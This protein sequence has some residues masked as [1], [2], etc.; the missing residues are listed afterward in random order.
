MKKKQYSLA[1]L[2]KTVKPGS[3]LYPW[4]T[5]HQHW[6]LGSGWGSEDKTFEKGNLF[7][8][9]MV[10]N[11]LVVIPNSALRFHI[12]AFRGKKHSKTYFVDYLTFRE[13]TLEHRRS[14]KLKV[15]M[16]IGIYLG[17]IIEVIDTRLIAI[18][19]LGLEGQI[20]W[21]LVFLKKS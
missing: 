10:V 18:K 17:E 8:Y 4:W 5:N 20:I 21:F 6:S 7:N 9:Q 15:G 11:P 14:L 12:E 2:K 3:F 1:D 13:L 19:F 16:P